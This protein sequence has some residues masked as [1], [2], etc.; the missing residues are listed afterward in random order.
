LEAFRVGSGGGA[1]D[2]WVI[3]GLVDGDRGASVGGAAGSLPITECSMTE[4]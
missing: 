3:D 1:L 2:F 4:P